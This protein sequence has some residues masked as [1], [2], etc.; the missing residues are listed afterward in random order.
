MALEGIAL[1]P[2][3]STAIRPVRRATVDPWGLVGDRRWMVTL[4]GGECLT[5]REDH[6]LF[7]VTADTPDSAT[8]LGCALRLRAAGRPDLLVQEPH[9]EPATVTVHGR[10][11]T[12]RDAGQEAAE[13]LG[14]SLGR[15]DVRLVH[16]ATPRGLNPRH[17]RPGEATAFA[18]GYPVTLASTVSLRR[19]RDWVT[20]VALE[21]GE[22][23][24]DIGIERFRPNLVVDGDLEPFAEDHWAS[25]TVGAVTFR[26]VKPVDRCVMTTIDPRSREGGREPIRTLARHR[27]WDGRTWFAV[28][29]VP[30]TAGELRIG[31]EVRPA[32]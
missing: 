7:A 25:V 32:G 5:A 21:R 14:V 11:L 4:P 15:D 24:T 3:K 30:E 16:V 26:V 13:W 18:D 2:V 22:E 23:P 27:A 6:G 10:P 8:G 31:D 17:A 12:G 28:Q 1:H 19:L 9:G 29:L 20:E